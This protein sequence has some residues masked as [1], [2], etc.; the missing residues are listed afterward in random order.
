MRSRINVTYAAAVMLC[1][2][3]ALLMAAALTPV[4]QADAPEPVTQADMC[5][6]GGNLTGS[7]WWLWHIYYNSE[8]S[9]GNAAENSVYHI[10]SVREVGRTAHVNYS[11]VGPDND[12]IFSEPLTS[13]RAFTNYDYP[14]AVIEDSYDQSGTEN[15]P[16]R[17]RVVFTAV[18]GL[19]VPVRAQNTMMDSEVYVKMNDPIMWLRSEQLP[20]TFNTDLDAGD[21]DVATDILLSAGEPGRAPRPGRRL[22]LRGRRAVL[23]AVD[24]DL[25]Q[26]RLPVPEPRPAAGA[27]L[28]V[29]RGQQ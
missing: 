6:L 21:G 26:W 5:G 11:A 14:A 10:S 12:R 23:D 19:G 16:A 9:G 13:P 28:Q 18:T 8:L 3:V 20:R 24:V 2:G 17:K 27:G 29:E 25:L 15:D 22:P 7:E 4:T 1:L